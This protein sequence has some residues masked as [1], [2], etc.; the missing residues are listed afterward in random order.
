MNKKLRKR[1]ERQRAKCSQK[2]PTADMTPKSR[3]NAQIA[4]SLLNPKRVPEVLRKRLFFGKLN[5]LMDETK[6]SAK[7]NNT[8]PLLES[9]LFEQLSKAMW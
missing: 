1:N 4:E 9:V 5:V 6:D 2:L 8:M 7:A 3:T